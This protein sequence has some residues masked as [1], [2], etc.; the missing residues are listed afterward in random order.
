MRSPSTS[1]FYYMYTRAAV[2][3]GCLLSGLSCQLWG[4]TGCLA[5]TSAMLLVAGVITIVLAGE[6]QGEAA[7]KA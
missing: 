4:L 3:V 7:A 2:P 1:G 6:Q 5:T